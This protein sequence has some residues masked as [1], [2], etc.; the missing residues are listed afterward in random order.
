MKV[1][2][3]GRILEKQTEEYYKRGGFLEISNIRN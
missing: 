1:W 2:N 3:L